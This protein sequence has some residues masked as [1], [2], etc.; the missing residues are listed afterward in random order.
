[1]ADLPDWSEKLFFGA[2]SARSHPRNASDFMGSSEL[3]TV[4][5][6]C[7]AFGRYCAAAQRE[8]MVKIAHSRKFNE[9][10]F[11]HQ[12]RTASLITMSPFGTFPTW[13]I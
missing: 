11:C 13:L 1:M 2:G 10:G 8:L 3:P 6:V 4:R 5:T 12:I 7:C 9:T